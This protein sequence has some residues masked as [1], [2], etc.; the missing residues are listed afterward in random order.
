MVC[1]W[2]QILS[3]FSFAILCS[4]IV[5]GFSSASL[6]GNA[7]FAFFGL[8]TGFFIV[9][10]KIPVWL[11]W[12]RYL[13]YPNICYSILA[14]NEF[15]DHRFACPN[16]GADGSWDDI[17]CAPWDG[18]SILVGQLDLKTKYYPGMKT[19]T[20]VQNCQQS[21]TRFFLLEILP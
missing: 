5:R 8:S 12:I 3:S 11:R 2:F 15:T 1:I 18:N 16:L 20:R 9:T 13:A 21:L 7:I 4:S 10:S 14:S 17:K 19:W 6:F